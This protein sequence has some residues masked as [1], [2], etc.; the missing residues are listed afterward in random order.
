MGLEPDPDLILLGASFTEP[1]GARMCGELLAAGRDMT[2]I[3]AANDLIALGCY[4]ALEARGVDCPAEISVVGFN[5]M[6]FVA[7]F[8][9]PLTTVRIPH[10]EMGVAAAQLVLE[11]IES[12]DVPAREVLLEPRLVVR[13]STAAPGGARPAGAPG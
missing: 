8:T 12:P 7:R 13:G 1:E 2:A 3:V 4:D 6:P 5:D 11:R 10:Y 9:P